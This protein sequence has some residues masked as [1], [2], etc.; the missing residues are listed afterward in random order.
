MLGVCHFAT[1][2]GNG[3]SWT[4][5][6]AGHPGKPGQSMV[7]TSG[8]LR[9]L[10]GIGQAGQETTFYVDEFHSRKGTLVP[11]GHNRSGLIYREA[12]PPIPTELDL[13]YT[14]YKS[15]CNLSSR[16]ANSIFVVPE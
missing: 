11:Y 9:L 8:Y 2:T 4:P 12:L 15:S 7:K 13:E 5:G 14:I 16:E 6:C 3:K 10:V 1:T